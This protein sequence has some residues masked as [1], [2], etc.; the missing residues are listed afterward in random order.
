MRTPDGKHLEHTFKGAVY[1]EM[2]EIDNIGFA[3][4]QITV[5]RFIIA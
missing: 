1:I 3:K 5:E 2:Q 4:H